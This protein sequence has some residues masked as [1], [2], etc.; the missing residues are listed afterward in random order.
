M[1]GDRASP[2]TTVLL[3]V[4]LQ[5]C[6]LLGCSAGA[7]LGT[8]APSPG[9]T[10]AATPTPGLP[11]GC[12]LL[13]RYQSGDRYGSPCTYAACEDG[14]VVREGGACPSGVVVPERLSAD[15]LAGIGERIAASDFFTL[16]SYYRAP[17]GC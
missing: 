12:V 14:R 17:D 5:S 16:G 2:R 13:L 15:Q 1:M 11:A 7:P 4:L 9:A 8:A 10:P 6:W 3:I